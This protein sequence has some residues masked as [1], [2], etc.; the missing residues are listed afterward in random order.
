MTAISEFNV[1]E[2]PVSKELIERVQFSVSSRNAEAKVGE[3]VTHVFASRYVEDPRAIEW[4]Y[5]ASG[6]I[7]LLRNKE[8]AKGGRKYAWSMNL[9]LYS[10]A[11]GVLVWKSKLSPGCGY[12]SVS[13]N[14]H[15]FS[16]TDFDAI[17]GLLFSDREQSAELYRTYSLWQQERMKDEKSK[18]G[19]PPPQAPRFKKEMIS[20]PCNFQHIQGTQALDECLEIEKM[21]GDILA[22]FFGLG[23]RGRT[24][25]DLGKKNVSGKRKKEV[26]KLRLEFG[27]I[28]VPHTSRQNA[29]SSMSPKSPHMSPPLEEQFQQDIQPSDASASLEPSPAD[30][31][32]GY[33]PQTEHYEPPL[34][35]N[36]NGYHGN[37]AGFDE[38]GYGNE[39]GGYGDETGGY[40]DE[41]GGHG[42]ETDYYGNEAGYYGNEAGYYGNEVPD[43]NVDAEVD[44]EVQ[45]YTQGLSSQ[46]SFGL[47]FPPPQRLSPLNMEEEFQQSDFF[48][49][50]QMSHLTNV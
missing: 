37:E 45:Q 8:L 7:C 4:Q 25:T 43:I 49:S 30:L 16:L 34:H 17:V 6:V 1:P 42:N 9:C 33:R 47:D 20:K 38:G 29:Q 41:T 3:C 50:I 27:K 36:P 10:A 23:P 46:G 26:I 35:D 39:T 22:A 5:V 24:E 12:T 28:E 18:A 48:S 31:Q 21:K 2:I 15:V 19:N 14:F 40:G 11:Y 32:N 44:A 13:D